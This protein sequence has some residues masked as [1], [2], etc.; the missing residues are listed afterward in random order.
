MICS[1]KMIALIS[2]VIYVYDVCNSNFQIF[3]NENM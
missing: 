2:F 1:M 3:W